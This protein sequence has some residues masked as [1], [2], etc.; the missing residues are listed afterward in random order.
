MSKAKTKRHRMPDLPVTASLRPQL[1]ALW[2]SIAFATETDEA[3]VSALTAATHGIKPEVLLPILLRAYLAAPVSARPRLDAVIPAWLAQSGHSEMMARV[4]TTQALDDESALVARAWLGRC[5]MQLQPSQAV[6]QD[7]FDRA[8]YYGDDSQAIV[9][10]FWFTEPRKRR[11]SGMSFL[12][13]YNPPWDG[14]VKDITAF[15][16]KSPDAVRDRF[17]TTWNERGMPL[18]VVSDAEAKQRVLTALAC[19]RSSNIRLPHDLIAARDAFVRWVLSRP[20]TARTP[21]F[22]SDDFDHLSRN[23]QFPEDIARYEQ[24]VGRR[25]RME[26][27]GEVLVMGSFDDED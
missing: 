9:L 22:T 6:T 16:V 24:T 2:G 13:D 21:T 11:M 3:C 26:D 20:D 15:P 12:I 27:G 1:D 14:A 25:V 7:L 23:G 8:Y 18:Q 17:V 19:N 4:V 5:G 10:L